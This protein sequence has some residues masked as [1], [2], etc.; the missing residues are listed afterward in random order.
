MCIVGGENSMKKKLS[1][2]LLLSGLLSL[3]IG[4]VSYAHYYS[5]GYSLYNIKYRLI[6]SAGSTAW[7]KAASNW[8]NAVGTT[9]SQDSTSLNGAHYGELAYSWFGLY[10]PT[11][12]PTS[13]FHVYV[14]TK[15]IHEYPNCNSNP[16]S[17]AIS[18][19]THELGHAQ[20]LNDIERYYGD[21]SIMS[22]ERN[23]TTITTPQAHDINDIRSYR[24]GVSST[25]NTDLYN[26]TPH[27]DWPEFNFDEL[28]SKRS[29]LI[30]QVKVID[31][32]EKPKV[33]GLPQAQL[34][35]LEVL[36]IIQGTVTGEII[37]DQALDFVVEGNTYIM[38]LKQRGDYYYESDKNSILLE[39]SGSYN[40]DIPDFKGKFTDVK[41][42]KLKFKFK[43][44]SL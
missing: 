2:V 8:T 28:V 5:S 39:E 20:F 25:S 36:D 14:N 17:C 22:Y 31:T 13:Y 43:K 44:S 41:T 6:D 35:T 40:S 38:M 42:F 21:S 29:D 15:A 23:R 12:S 3:A 34:A 32:K 16:G 9:I 26:P 33:D 10:S 27:A 30:V 24:N 18:T 37:L 1:K 4:S 19:A 11:G 7:S